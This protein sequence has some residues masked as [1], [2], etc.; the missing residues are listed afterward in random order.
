VT[1]NGPL[2]RLLH[3]AAWDPVR[4]R[5][6]FQ[7]GSPDNVRTV[8][9]T[10]A[11]NVLGSEVPTAT[12]SATATAPTATATEATATAPTATATATVTS[13]GPTSTATYGSTPTSTGT[14]TATQD[15]PGPSPTTVVDAVEVDIQDFMFVPD[16]IRIRVGQTVRWTNRDEVPHTTTSGQP[17][18][19]DDRWDSDILY[20]GEAYEQRFDEAGRFPYYCK[21]HPNMLGTVIVSDG[22]AE[23]YPWLYLPALEKP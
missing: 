3:A 22:I 13:E 2:D 1:Y 9:D 8:R 18:S 4:D 7:G 19:P 16:P 5:G 12:A 10:R 20:Q 14:P 21:V 23:E 11:L 15:A 17:G 6:L